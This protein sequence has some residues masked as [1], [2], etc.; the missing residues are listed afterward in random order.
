MKSNLLLF[1]CCFFYLNCNAQ[2]NCVGLTKTEISNLF[3][4]KYLG[5]EQSTGISEKG[6]KYVSY[7]KEENKESDKAYNIKYFFDEEN[8]CSE[9]IMI[10]TINNLVSMLALLNSK[11]IKAGKLKWVDETGTQVYTMHTD[12][13]NFWLNIYS[14]K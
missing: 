2:G 8:L 6:N 14:I 13:T 5:W 4:T 12:D 7:F 10:Y 3:K 1:L 11:Y 9:T